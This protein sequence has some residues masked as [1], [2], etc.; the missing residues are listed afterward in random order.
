MPKA[1]PPYPAEFREQAVRLALSS[2]K[3]TA[4]IAADLGISY[5]T[6][7]KW[8]MRHEVD[9]GNAPG[10]TSTERDELRRLRRENR[11]LKEERDI[12]RKAAAYFARE[13]R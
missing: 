4:E 7:R 11:I 8:I 13:T 3:R 6:L 12:L 5:E 1:P 2:D 10:V 9:G